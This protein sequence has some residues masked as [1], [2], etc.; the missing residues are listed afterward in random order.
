MHANPI[1]L[2]DSV[3]T[4]IFRIFQEALTNISRHAHATEV[5][6]AVTYTDNVLSVEVRDNGQ[7][8]SKTE[9]G[10]SKSY[11][12]VSMSERALQIGA[13]LEINSEIGKG[14][15]VVLRYPATAGERA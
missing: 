12:L 3:A 1:E 15:Q 7:G 4:A 11:G 13:T 2:D 6:I 14:T 9:L 8:I 5:D 10:H